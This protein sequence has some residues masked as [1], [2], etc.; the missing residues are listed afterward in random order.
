MGT[1]DTRGGAPRHDPAADVFPACDIC[2]HEAGHCIC[3]ECPV[4]GTQGDPKCY[5]EHFQPQQ[6]SWLCL[7]GHHHPTLQ[8]K[9]ACER[10]R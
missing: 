7:H 3:P 1:Y 4:C 8:S 5:G 9:I 6:S 2:G 10:K